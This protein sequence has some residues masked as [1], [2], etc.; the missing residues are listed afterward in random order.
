MG[1]FVKINVTN[2]QNENISFE[3]KFPKDIQIAELKVN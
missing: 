1:D 3:K 2:S